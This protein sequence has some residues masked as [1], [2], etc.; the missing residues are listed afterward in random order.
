[1]AGEFDDLIPTKQEQPDRPGGEPIVGQ[2][3]GEFGLGVAEAGVAVG[4]SALLAPFA[5]I[6]GLGSLAGSGAQSIMEEIEESIGTEGLKR[7]LSGEAEVD[8][9]LRAEAAFNKV[10]GASFTP[11]TELGQ[12]TLETVINGKYSP[13]RLIQITS[14]FLGDAVFEETGSVGAA[15]TV[16]S[17]TDIGASI[18]LEL[19]RPNFGQS[20]RDK[21]I[22]NKMAKDAGVDLDQPVETILEDIISRVQEKTDNIQSR[23]D[24]V[25]VAGD[26]V[27]RAKAT[28]RNVDDGLWRSA[29][30]GNAEV[31][32]QHIRNFASAA[33]DSLRELGFSVTD[34][35]IK[36]RLQ[37]LRDGDFG[38]KAFLEGKPGNETFVA[39]NDLQLWRKKLN[40]QRPP[41]ADA[42][43]NAALDILKAEHDKFLR[44]KFIT[45][46]IRGD[47][48]QI[49]AYERAINL[50]A[51]YK[52][53]FSNKDGIFR[54]LA[55]HDATPLEMKSFIFGASKTAWKKDTA[56]IV[57]QLE[58]LLGKDS[59]GMTAIKQEALFDMMEPLLT[60]DPDFAGF[61]K[62]M[63]GFLVNNKPA[64][65]ALFTKQEIAQLQG[66]KNIS[67]AIK[68]N[69]RISK[70]LDLDETVSRLMIGNKLAKAA[71]RVSLGARVLRMIRESASKSDKRLI[72]GELLGYDPFRP[73]LSGLFAGTAAITAGGFEQQRQLQEQQ[74]NQQNTDAALDVINQSGVF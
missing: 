22:I 13:F 62:R 25:S 18:V 35:I 59:P 39:L 32:M 37:E 42:S 69:K 27:Q 31:Q 6:A 46:M 70:S 34:P 36:K 61:V 72:M 55:V 2:F 74:R 16:A 47:P 71:V 54:Q 38:Q 8:P 43:A 49:A 66:L 20:A 29:R 3:V 19:R 52:K 58:Q 12:Q 63:D 15:G 21:K 10:M 30:Q 68:N 67:A 60:K 57:N 7:E 41:K 64:L 11:Q 45:D 44:N 33:E 23:G 48:D 5:G 17:L 40:K 4:T 28:I 53:L 56:R 9:L 1:M 51:D 65:D 73:P 24:R 26:A 14:E 50:H